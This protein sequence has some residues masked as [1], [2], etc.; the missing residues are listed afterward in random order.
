V[1][2]RS[3]IRVVATDEATASL[4]AAGAVHSF[5]APRRLLRRH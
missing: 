5:A 4:L 1:E 2:S 3:P